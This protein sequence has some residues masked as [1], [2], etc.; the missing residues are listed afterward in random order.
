MVGNEEDS[1]SFPDIPSD[2]QQ[3]TISETH[4]KY[5]RSAVSASYASKTRRR[6]S[7]V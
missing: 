5:G 3:A 4:K 6:V 1:D 7:S 2:W